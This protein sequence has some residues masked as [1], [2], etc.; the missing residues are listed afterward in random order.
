MTAAHSNQVET[1]R[2]RVSISMSLNIQV[3]SIKFKFFEQNKSS[4]FEGEV[5]HFLPIFFTRFAKYKEV[6]LWKQTKVQ[7]QIS[8]SYGVAS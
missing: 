1:C 5:R 2:T 7:T 6:R 8:L 3:K 4:K